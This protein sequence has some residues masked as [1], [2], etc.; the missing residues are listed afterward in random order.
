MKIVID[1]MGGDNGSPIIIKAIKEF[2]KTYTDVEI[3]AVGDKE[4][5]KELNNVA[6]VIPSK[7]VLDMECGVMDALRDKESSIFVA[8]E[9]VLKGADAIVSA[10]STG[11]YLSLSTLKLKKIEGVLRPAL[12]T[13]VPTKI[14]GKEVVLLD[15]GASSENTAKELVQFGK[16]GVA[17]AKGL[18]NIKEPSMYLLSNGTEE[19]KGS[20]LYKETYELLKTNQYFKGNI[21]GREILSGNADIVVMDGFAGNVVLKTIEGTAKMISGLIKDAFTSSFMSKIGYLFS[22]K[23]FDEM[24]SVMDYKRVG[25]ALLIGVNSLVIK[26]HGNSDDKAFYQAIKLAY[27]LAKNDTL[28]KIKESIKNEAN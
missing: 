15:I 27:N 22:K 12:I 19:G 14:K 16:M 11:A 10:G 23:G 24:K 7:T 18:Y 2:K 17:Y 3:V 13:P 28:N 5:L 1:A 20:S 6:T 9:E 4:Q 21:E 25:G 8:I 26:A